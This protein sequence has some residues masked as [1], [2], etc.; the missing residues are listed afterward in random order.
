M[1]VKVYQFHLQKDK[2]EEYL[3]IQEKASAIYSKYI[4]FETM[5]LNSKEDETKWIEIT[6]Y[7]DEIEYN[8]SIILVNEEQEIHDLFNQFQSLLLSD[9]NEILE[10][11]FVQIKK[12][13]TF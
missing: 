4:R 6:R 3:M 11:D 8:R 13:S 2:V 7:K 5:Y 9:K 1:Y 12:K 10:E